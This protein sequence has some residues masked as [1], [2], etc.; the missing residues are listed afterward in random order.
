MEGLRPVNINFL[1]HAGIKNSDRNIFY[2]D[3]QY[4]YCDYNK[5]QAD[6]L[7]ATV[8]RQMGLLHLKNKFG[9]ISK[10]LF[11]ASLVAQW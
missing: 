8:N 4:F 3:H 7:E 6:L 10:S 5:I 1:S 2:F 11:K 9:E